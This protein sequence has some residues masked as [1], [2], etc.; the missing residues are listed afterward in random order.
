[1]LKPC[2]ECEMQVRHKLESLYRQKVLRG[3]SGYGGVAY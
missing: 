1:M 3:E 2:P